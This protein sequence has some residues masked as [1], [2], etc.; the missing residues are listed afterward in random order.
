MPESGRWLSADPGGLI[1]GLNLFRFCRNNPV[2]IIDTNGLGCI[3]STLGSEQETRHDNTPAASSTSFGITH[4]P[5]LGPDVLVVNNLDMEFGA[6]Y[7][8]GDAGG[9]NSYVYMSRHKPSNTKYITKAMFSA[10]YAQGYLSAKNEVFAYIVS[11]KLQLGLVPH[12]AYMQKNNKVI[13]IKQ[14]GYQAKKEVPHLPHGYGNI[15]EYIISEF[16]KTSNTQKKIGEQ[17]VNRRK[18]ILAVFDYLI[19]QRDRQDGTRN[20]VFDGRN[21]LYAIDNSIIL[22]D[23]VVEPADEQV[24]QF[25]SNTDTVDAMR[26]TDWSSLFDQHYSEVLEKYPLYKK[27]EHNER[28]IAFLNRVARV[29]AIFDNK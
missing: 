12:T 11:E 6:L 18:T 28:K 10:G 24:S 14:N 4:T 27:S 8:S 29:Q 22:D 23:R 20:V 26:K 15:N 5:K 16:I 21:N 1:D 2:N 9:Q 17:E 25:M 3:H 13:T 7:E 19:G